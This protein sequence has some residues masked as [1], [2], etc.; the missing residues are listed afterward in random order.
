MNRLNYRKINASGQ[1]HTKIFSNLPVTK[2]IQNKTTNSAK[3][4]GACL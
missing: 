2:E 3:D 1:K 4:G